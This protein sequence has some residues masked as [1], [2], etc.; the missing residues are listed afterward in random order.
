MILQVNCTPEKPC[1]LRKMFCKLDVRRKSF[2]TLT[3]SQDN[4]EIIVRY[5]VNQASGYIL[6]YRRKLT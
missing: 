6:M 4:R 3:L 2:V 5:F 1:A